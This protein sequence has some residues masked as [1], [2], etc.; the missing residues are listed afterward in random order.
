MSYS[1]H[2]LHPSSLLSW[3]GITWHL[4]TS[5]DGAVSLVSLECFWSC[6]QLSERNT[7]ITSMC[8]QT[9]GLKIASI[10]ES[11]WIQFNS[12]YA[13]RLRDDRR[14]GDDRR[15]GDSSGKATTGGKE[16]FCICVSVA[17]LSSAVYLGYDFIDETSAKTVV[18]LVC[19]ILLHTC[20]RLL[21][22]FRFQT[23]SSATV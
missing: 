9:R 17:M 3:Q 11:T 21:F 19:E 12:T 20:W 13:Q 10:T 16:R 7:L 4:W 15:H 5:V 23:E 1:V 18:R 6:G 22:S 2:L 14:Q 8:V